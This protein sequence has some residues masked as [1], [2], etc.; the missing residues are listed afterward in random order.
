METVVIVIHLLLAIALVVTVLLQQSEGGALGIGGSTMGGF[1]TGRGAANLL[2]R[3][4]SVLAAGFFATSII[5]TIL[6]RGTVTTP[7]ILDS[8]PA[9]EKSAPK[10][11]TPSVPSSE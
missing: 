10:P 5:L 2:T 6:A 7:S 8:V 11:E 9:V 1:M 4:T 3:V